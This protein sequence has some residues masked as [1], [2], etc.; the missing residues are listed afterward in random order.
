MDR[1][2][3]RKGSLIGSRSAS[4]RTR[5]PARFELLCKRMR[6]PFSPLTPAMAPEKL[7]WSVMT[8]S[9]AGNTSQMPCRAAAWAARITASVSSSRPLAFAPYSSGETTRSRRPGPV[10]VAARNCWA[11]R[12]VAAPAPSVFRN[13]LLIFPPRFAVI[14]PPTHRAT[15]RPPDRSTFPGARAPRK[16]AGTPAQGCRAGSC[17]ARCLP[18]GPQRSRP[19]LPRTG[20]GPMACWPA[21]R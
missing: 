7:T 19:G 1:P 18:Q 17:R 12:N 3:T 20:R 8:Y 6:L 13:S 14:D 2:D 9:P 5:K 4:S 15:A 16:A 11:I 10:G 21:A